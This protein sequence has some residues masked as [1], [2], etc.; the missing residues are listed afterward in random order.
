MLKGQEPMPSSKMRMR[1][2]SGTWLSKALASERL[3]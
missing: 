1:Y 3:P 2:T